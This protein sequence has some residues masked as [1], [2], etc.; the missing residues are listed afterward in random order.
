M[1]DAI[2]RADRWLRTFELSTVPD[3]AAILLGLER[4][5]DE[6]ARSQR[7]RALVV[8]RRGQ[9]PDGGWGPYTSSPPEPFDTAVAVL[10]LSAIDDATADRA[11][12]G[13]R[14][15]VAIARGRQLLIGRQLPDG[16]WPET[17]R[18]AGQESYAQRIST[19]GWA[20]LALLANQP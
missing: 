15:R 10:A 14:R 5:T 13:N 3:A 8:L 19:A 12:P 7:A 9:S 4:A 1:Q 18:P 11:Y 16:S 17:T 20:T 2:A 6:G